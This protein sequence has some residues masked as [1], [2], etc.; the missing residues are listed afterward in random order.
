MSWGSSNWTLKTIGALLAAIGVDL[1][2]PGYTSFEA[3]EQRLIQG[4]S[5]TAVA[6]ALHGSVDFSPKD[7]TPQSASEMTGIG[8]TE[9][10]RPQI[11]SPLPA[12]NIPKQRRQRSAIEKLLNAQNDQQD[13]AA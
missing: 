11:P 13:E 7:R 6:S 12:Y 5:T 2:D 4:P 8:M 1:D 3:L 10:K 9:K